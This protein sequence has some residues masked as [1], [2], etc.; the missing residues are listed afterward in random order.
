MSAELPVFHIFH[1]K[2]CVRKIHHI[3]GCILCKHGFACKIWNTGSSAPI[4]RSPPSIL[5]CNRAAYHLLVL[6]NKKIDIAPIFRSLEQCHNLTLILET[7]KI[8]AASIFVQTNTN[9]WYVTLFY[10]T[11]L[12]WPQNMV[13][14]LLKLCSKHADICVRQSPI[15]GLI[16]HPRILGHRFFSVYTTVIFAAHTIY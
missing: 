10:I 15:I 13:R 2:P 1:P 14:K 4:F 9:A 11:I 7:M 6:E 5:L 8:V 3:L 16:S 12:D